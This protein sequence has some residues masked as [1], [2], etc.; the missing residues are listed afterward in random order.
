M[1]NSQQKEATRQTNTH[2]NTVASALSYVFQFLNP[3]K[4]SDA[5]ISNGGDTNLSVPDVQSALANY[6]GEPAV[7]RWKTIPARVVAVC[8]RRKGGAS[9]LL[10]RSDNGWWLPFLTPKSDES[11]LEAVN[12]LLRMVSAF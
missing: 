6:D 3:S 10:S 7:P 1:S 12:R 2:S 11:N 5:P 8:A 4:D 9:C